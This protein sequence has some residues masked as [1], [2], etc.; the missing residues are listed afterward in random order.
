V[1]QRLVAASQLG[2][3]GLA[4]LFP[5]L[6]QRVGLLLIAGGSRDERRGSQACEDQTIHHAGTQFVGHRRTCFGGT[7][8]P[9]PRECIGRAEFAGLDEES[10][11]A[12]LSGYSEKAGKI[13]L[14]GVARSWGR[15]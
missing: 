12:G 2:G 3:N 10:Q 9:C 13:D 8:R 11:A 4:K 14:A 7:D 15:S 6:S 1:V 5:L